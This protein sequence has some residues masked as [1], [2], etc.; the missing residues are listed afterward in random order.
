MHSSANPSLEP[1]ATTERAVM[2]DTWSHAPLA[3]ESRFDA[4]VVGSGA[5]GGVAADSLCRQG[6]RVAVFEAGFPAP[7][8]VHPMTRALGGMARFLASV[9]A[10]RRL[11]PR[12]AYLGERA[13]RLLGRARQ[14]IQSRCF[15]WAL[16]PG[17]FVDDVDCPY[18]TE[19]DSRFHWFRARQPGG[20]MLVPGH[21]MQYYRLAGMERTAPD[22][23][24]P[25]WPIGLDDLDAWYKL[26]EDRL[27]LK[28]S[29]QASGDLASSSLSTILEPTGSEQR[30][31]EVIRAKWPQARP[32]L[33]THAP[34]VAWL[35]D[36]AASGNLTGQAGAVVRQVLR[37]GAGNCNGV[38]WFDRSSG[39]ARRAT[40]PIVFLCASSIE[41]TRILLSSRSGSSTVAIGTQSEALG[42]Y[43]M[44]HAVMSGS[45]YRSD[46]ADVLP[47]QSLPGRCIYLPPHEATGGNVGFQIYVTARKANEVGFVIVSFAEMLPDKW[48]RVTLDPTR[49]DRFGMPIP[50]IR[51][52]HSDEQHAIAGQQARIIQE[53]AEASKLTGVAV[54]ARLSPG[55]TSIHEC[56][57]ARMG[58][59]PATSVVDPNN[60]CW[61]IKGLYVTDGACF[62]RQHVHNPT[63]TIMA[64]TARAAAHAASKKR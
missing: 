45:G 17:T 50:V 33:G 57:T 62:P 47:E 59:D 30:I 9:D 60:E 32:M 46:L 19:A 27:A 44:D 28:G 8:A 14:P 11:P 36:A 64:L 54:N 51:F 40:A 48:N 29:A 43:L 39:V 22:S 21:G 42:S 56:G 58:E 15:A 37:D 24:L 31:M 3:D 18:R 10:Q 35:D 5:A 34:A 4:I 1:S 25:G 12:L 41:T 38:E 16:A 26:V 49:L 7:Q 23:G 6:L 52:R 53:I 2:M 61:D 55:G 13:F 63:L 20:R